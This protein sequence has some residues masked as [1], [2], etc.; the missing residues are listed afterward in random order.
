MRSVVAISL[1]VFLL[2]SAA[3]AK[4]NSVERAERVSKTMCSKAEDFDLCMLE[5]NLALGAAYHEGLTLAGCKLRIE[6]ISKEECEDSERFEHH[7]IEEINNYSE[8]M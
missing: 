6:G 2:N 4:E 7:I 3:F 1:F 8:K 5:M